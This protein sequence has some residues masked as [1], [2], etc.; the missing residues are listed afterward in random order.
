M[1]PNQGPPNYPGGGG[2]PGGQP[3]GFPGPGGPNQQ[4]YPQGGFPH[5]PIYQA[6]IPHQ[7][8]P[9][10]ATPQYPQPGGGGGAGGSGGGAGGGGQLP[11]YMTMQIKPEPMWSQDSRYGM[12]PGTSGIPGGQGG[13]G[14]HGGGQQYHGMP[15]NVDMGDGRNSI[16]PA[17]VR[18]SPP[19]ASHHSA[20]ATN[21]SLLAQHLATAPL[22]PP[23]PPQQAP[24]LS[25]LLQQPMY[26][27]TH[28]GEGPSGSGG[29][30]Q[31]Q[32]RERGVRTTMTPRELLHEQETRF[33][34]L[35]MARQQAYIQQQQA[36]QAAQQEYLQQTR[37]AQLQAEQAAVAAAAMAAV[38]ANTSNLIPPL[39][40]GFPPSASSSHSA[41]RGAQEM[42]V[43]NQMVPLSMVRESPHQKDIDLNKFTTGELCLY[44]R[45]LVNELNVKTSHLSLM[46][47]KVMER[48]TLNQG[49]NPNE[50]AAH[51]RFN[52]ERMSEI[53][54]IIEGRREPAWK[55]LSGDEYI[56]LML[57]DS[58]L[59]KPM[60]EEQKAKREEL[61]QRFPHILSKDP[62]KEG[63]IFYQGR[64]IPPALH[65]KYM[66]FEAN[67]TILRNLSTQLKAVAWKIDVTSPGHLK[68]VDQTKISR[69]KNEEPSN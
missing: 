27:G 20:A 1:H 54:Q 43:G 69:K 47:K 23:V 8:M 28:P 59:A 11:A 53:R 64:W 65:A 6:G 40:Q 46:L 48:K 44:G 12:G 45:E 24:H 61:E 22:P 33:A 30:G 19:P 32:Q 42:A 7:Y 14:G 36:Y 52:L 2:P 39:A 38:P 62:P 50:L 18:Y 49:E 15:H 31:Q 5:Y 37:A 26:P 4:G 67:K 34:Q 29:G 56:E 58:E 17:P 16:A 57:D 3:P 9:P 51:C 10:P 35:Q 13:Y 55:R 68:R 25:H 63:H 60:S 41:Y 21:Q 66:T